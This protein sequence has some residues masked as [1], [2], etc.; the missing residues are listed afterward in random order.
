MESSEPAKGNEERMFS[1]LTDAIRVPNGCVGGGIRLTST[2]PM[3][4]M[5]ILKVR[6]GDLITA[7]VKGWYSTPA[8]SNG[9]SG[10]QLWL[11][12]V[13]DGNVPGQS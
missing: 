10:L 7:K 2:Q 1:H 4:P 12:A 11:Q 5:R 3:G 13:P 6:R 9:G 8:S